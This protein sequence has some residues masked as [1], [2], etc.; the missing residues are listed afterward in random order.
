MTDPSI[1]A[2]ELAPALA[3]LLA[4]LGNG[5]LRAGTARLF[6]QPR[7]LA[8][9]ALAYRAA[10]LG[11]LALDPAQLQHCAE[12]Y[13]QA[14]GN[15]QRVQAELG[16]IAEWF[17]A[18][19]IALLVLKGGA[20]IFDLYA[21]PGI[22]PAGDLDLLVPPER[23]EDA[24]RI[25]QAQGYTLVSA[26]LRHGLRELAHPNR[27]AGKGNIDLHS[28]VGPWRAWTAP[29]YPLDMDGIWRR[30]A[31]LP[32]PGCAR[33]PLQMSPED[34]LLF[35]CFQMATHGF[36]KLYGYFD[37]HALIVTGRVDHARLAALAPGHPF[38]TFAYCGFGVARA[39]LGTPVPA[40]WPALTRPSALRRALI[41]R[42]AAPARIAAARIPEDHAVQFVLLARAPGDVARMGVSFA[43]YDAG[44]LA[45]RDAP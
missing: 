29:G 45:G 19:N 4:Q 8:L 39:M 31:P 12:A 23:L 3:H 5:D 7:G 32:L 20:F 13:F 43:R 17:A 6:T 35:V 30:A 14:A 16:R 37:V 9:H 40:A 26:K 1:G 33:P 22:R 10:R 41:A 2:A 36:N 42:W 28:R 38:R 15:Q 34:A 11:Q 25:L 44:K 21:E 27:P 24:T 18:E